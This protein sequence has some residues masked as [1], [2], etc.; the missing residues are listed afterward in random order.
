[1]YYLEH[2][3]S[4]LRWKSLFKIIKNVCLKTITYFCK[5]QKITYFFTT[6][7]IKR[8]S[9]F[10]IIM[11][12]DHR[13]FGQWTIMYRQFLVTIYDT[14]MGVVYFLLQLIDPFF[15]K[16]TADVGHLFYYSIYLEKVPYLVFL[17]TSIIKENKL[18]YQCFTIRLVLR[19]LVCLLQK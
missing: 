8:E 11:R 5:V 4:Y 18:L 9:Y 3:T 10:L 2:P 6:K 14:F 7:R 12:K 19:L 13:K 15:P 16:E 17:T 1:M